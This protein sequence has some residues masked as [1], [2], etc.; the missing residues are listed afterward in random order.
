MVLT[1]GWMAGVVDEVLQV[2]AAWRVSILAQLNEEK[3]YGRIFESEIKKRPVQNTALKT[4]G[5][6]V[7]KHYHG[8][9]VAVGREAVEDIGLIEPSSALKVGE[10]AWVGIGISFKL[11]DPTTCSQ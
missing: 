11:L 1:A 3:C 8:F 2:L 10:R 9:F 7:A 6:N 4:C 5:Q